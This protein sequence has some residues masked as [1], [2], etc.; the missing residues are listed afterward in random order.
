MLYQRNAQANSWW[1]WSVWVY[2]LNETLHPDLTHIKIAYIN[3][4]GTLNLTMSIPNLS[5]RVSIF[6]PKIQQLHTNFRRHLLPGQYLQIKCFK[7]C[8]VYSSMALNIF[9]TLLQHSHNGNNH[10]IALLRGKAER[11]LVRHRLKDVL[12]TY[13]ATVPSSKSAPS[14]HFRR[15]VPPTTWPWF[16][17]Q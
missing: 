17:D 2:P 9:A 15:K 11:T 1:Y 14:P 16:Q 4:S 7:H 3:F 13:H 10:H 6:V 5:G 8:F 12:K